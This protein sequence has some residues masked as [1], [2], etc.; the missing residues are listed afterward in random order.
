[1]V[2]TASQ[3]EKQLGWKV[4]NATA[5]AVAVVVTQRVLT[6]IWR[7]VHGGPPPEGP[8]DRRVTL[9]AALTWAVAMGA[10]VAVSRLIAIRLAADAW[11]VA[12]HRPPPGSEI[13]GGST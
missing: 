6:V 10:G 11:E 8:A 9:G 5:S 3:T 2:R 1:M 7:R 4:L 12:T 13:A